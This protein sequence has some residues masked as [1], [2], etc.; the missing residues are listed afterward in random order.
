MVRRFPP[1]RK[2]E[3]T[4]GGYLV[5]DATGQALAYVYGR[6]KQA[7]ADTAKLLASASLQ[8]VRR[9]LLR[10]QLRLGRQVHGPLLV[11]LQTHRPHI[12]CPTAG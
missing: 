5:S 9:Q 11:N 8:F 2:V 6:E 4:L 7:D 10:G 12:F 3:N 1:P